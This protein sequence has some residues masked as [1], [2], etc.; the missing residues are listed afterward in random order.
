[1]NYLDE[2]FRQTADEGYFDFARCQRPNGTFYGTGGTCRKGDKVGAAEAEPAAKKRGPKKGGMRLTKRVLEMSKGDLQ[3]VLKDP[4][5]NDAQKQRIQDIIAK[6]PSDPSQ[7]PAA[8]AARPVSP[9]VAA[10]VK[11][12]MAAKAKDPYTPEQKA[13]QDALLA[14]NPP[15]V[16]Q[17]KK[18]GRT[19]E[20]QF[21]RDALKYD[22]KIDRNVLAQRADL[23]GTNIEMIAR[24]KSEY[25]TM[26]SL[27]KDPAFQTTGNRS[28][29]INM[30]LA[31]WEKERQLRERQNRPANPRD[32][33]AVKDSP[34]YSK[35]PGSTK[36]IA[37][38]EEADVPTLTKRKEKLS[39]EFDTLYKKISP[40]DQERARML[41]ISNEMLDIGKR[42][43]DAN[44][45]RPP[46]PPALKDVYEQQG[47]NAKPELV[48]STSDLKKRDD[49]LRGSDGQN[50][51]I[52]RGVTT[53]E[54]SDQFKGLGPDG[55]KH[56]AGRGIFGNGTY[57]AA[58]DDAK[59]Q[60]SAAEP[61]KTA[62]A[63]AGDPKDNNV[64]VTAF[65]LRRDANVV[66]FKGDFAE[67]TK[68][69]DKWYDDTI[70]EARKKTG[71][72]HTDVGEA[73]AALGIHGYQTPQRGEDFYVILNRGAVVAAMD[74]QID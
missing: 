3:K 33:Q 21:Q 46:R 53:P 32:A 36:P 7:T 11:K 34:K 26:Q 25:R 73:A 70:D 66:T 29:M 45:D 38:A 64:N 47:F 12:A 1:M 61:I 51:I 23:Q 48:G 44:A 65:G 5:L 35:T 14:A 49:L 37:R 42:I 9:K 54:F 30:R 55:T 72:Y 17:R 63:Y 24:M 19:I 69:F 71:Y 31:I 18:T 15:K 50:V 6:K 43:Q 59:P 16:E 58:A 8:K 20:E 10:K 74:P 22:V 62:K 27:M 2:V 56:F 39:K 68:Q 28:R 13:A 52:Y 4:R 41:E 40:S 60:T 67:R 57:G